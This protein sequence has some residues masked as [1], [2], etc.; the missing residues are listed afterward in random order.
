MKPQLPDMPG[1]ITQRINFLAKVLDL[2]ILDFEKQIGASNGTIA[3]AIK[4][5]RDLSGRWCQIIIEKYEVS[6]AWL[7]TGKDIPANPGNLEKIQRLSLKEEIIEAIQIADPQLSGDTA[8][9]EKEIHI[10]AIKIMAHLD[11]ANFCEIQEILDCARSFASQTLKFDAKSP[12]YQNYLDAAAKA[13]SE[14]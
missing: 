1:T 8:K 4:Y 12:A 9:A 7:M 5:N 14:S 2:R 13:E 6:A 3:K 10:R 11:G